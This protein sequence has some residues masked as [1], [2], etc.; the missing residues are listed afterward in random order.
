MGNVFPKR[1]GPDSSRSG[2]V[3]QSGAAPVQGN[4]IPHPDREARLKTG[5]TDLS[6]NFPNARQRA[7]DAILRLIKMLSGADHTLDHRRAE[8]LKVTLIRALAVLEAIH[9][10]PESVSKDELESL[11]QAMMLL[12]D[13]ERRESQ[14]RTGDGARTPGSP[15]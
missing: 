13:V 4:V 8:E 3:P 7:S 11:K 5:I 9:N 14:R 10:R 6:A 15:N 1:K 12:H 2:P